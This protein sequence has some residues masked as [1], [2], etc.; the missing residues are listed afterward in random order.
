MG[1]T[2]RK[3][4]MYEGFLSKVSILGGFIGYIV[5]MCT[6]KLHQKEENVRGVPPARSPF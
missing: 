5:Y 2:I 1:S 4:K 3:R 6:V